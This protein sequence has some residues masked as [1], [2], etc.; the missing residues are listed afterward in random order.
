MVD[1][2][3]PCQSICKF[4]SCKV[5]TLLHA[6][7]FSASSSACK[8]C[9]WQ[10][11]AEAGWGIR[12]WSWK[13]PKAQ[14]FLFGDAPGL[15]L[16]NSMVPGIDTVLWIRVLPLQILALMLIPKHVAGPISLK[17]L[18]VKHR[19]AELLLGESSWTQPHRV[20][21]VK[22]LLNGCSSQPLWLPQPSWL[23]PK[24]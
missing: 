20:G 17:L 1:G 14:D 13:C 4:S 18:N 12:L 5:P 11:E 24:H 23:H 10:V 7:I 21:E 19:G 9:K 6:C 8:M 22:E 3:R 16:I 15:T 2:L